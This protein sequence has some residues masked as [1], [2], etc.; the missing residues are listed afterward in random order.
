MHIGFQ[1]NY[2]FNLLKIFSIKAVKILIL[3]TIIVRSMIYNRAYYYLHIEV[4]KL[5][6]VYHTNNIQPLRISI[7][8]VT[9]ISTLIKDWKRWNDKS[10]IEILFHSS[11]WIRSLFW[12]GCEDGLPLVLIWMVIKPLAWNLLCVLS[13]SCNLGS[14]ELLSKKCWFITMYQ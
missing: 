11:F 9:L 2:I 13:E 3:Q 14:L 6:V 10:D 7:Q 8:N 4:Y 12:Y 1:F 5:Q